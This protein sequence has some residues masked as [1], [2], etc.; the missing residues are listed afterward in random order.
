MQRYRPAV[1]PPP[2]VCDGPKPASSAGS[3][4]QMLK[5][6]FFTGAVTETLMQ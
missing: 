5:A 2:L 3:E 1:P 4:K 6:L